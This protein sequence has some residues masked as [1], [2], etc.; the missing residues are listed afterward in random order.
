MAINS[1]TFCRGNMGDVAQGDMILSRKVVLGR[2]CHNLRTK[3]PTMG[4]NAS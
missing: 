1:S 4:S 2:T 3:F